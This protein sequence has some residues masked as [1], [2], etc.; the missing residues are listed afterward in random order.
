MQLLLIKSVLT[1]WGCR[2][3]PIGEDAWMDDPGQKAVLWKHFEMG[4][5]VTVKIHKVS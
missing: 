1:V 2:L 4:K 5:V 3:I